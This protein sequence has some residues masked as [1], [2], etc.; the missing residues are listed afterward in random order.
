MIGYRTI[1]AHQDYAFTL[2]T[3]SYLCARCVGSKRNVRFDL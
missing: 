3:I 2:R 1:K